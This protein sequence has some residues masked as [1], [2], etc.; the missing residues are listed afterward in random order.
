MHLQAD[1]D[2]P[3]A[4]VLDCVPEGLPSDPVPCLI[5]LDCQLWLGVDHGLGEDVLPDPEHVDLPVEGGH[6]AGGFQHPGVC[7]GRRRLVRQRRQEARLGRLLG[8]RTRPPLDPQQVAP[9]AGA[10]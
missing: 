1:V 8:A 4:G 2:V 10:D 3:R 6:L 7:R 5:D 9:G